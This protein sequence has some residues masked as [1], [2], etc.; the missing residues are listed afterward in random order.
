MAPV[1]TLKV[2]VVAAATTMTE[3]GTVRVELVLETATLAPP[4]GAGC[5]SVMV[6][7]LEELGP[8]LVGLHAREETWEVREDCVRLIKVLAEVPS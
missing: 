5:V 3:A 6:Q 1:V 2:A 7:G 8:R 4:L